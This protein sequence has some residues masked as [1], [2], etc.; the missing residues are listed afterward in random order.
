MIQGIGDGFIPGVLYI[1]LID[2]VVTISAEKALET[3]RSLAHEEGLMGRTS[4]GTNRFS[5]LQM[6]DGRKKVV[7]VLPDRAERYFSTSLLKSI[8]NPFFWRFHYKLIS[9]QVYITATSGFIENYFV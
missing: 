5:A 9:N 6:D 3:T 1:N 2:M 8:F 7:T 4:S